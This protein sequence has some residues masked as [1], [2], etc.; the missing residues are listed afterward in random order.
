MKILIKTLRITAFKGIRDLTLDL[1]GANAELSG[2][3]GTGKT[4]VYDAYLWLLFGK[5]ST[6][7]S[8]F[9]VKPL[10]SNGDRLTGV[11]TSVECDILAGGKGVTLKRS[12]HEKWSKVPGNAQP[13]YTGDETLCWIDGVPV[14]LVNEYQPYINQLVGGEDS[15]KLLSSHGAFMRLPWD[16]QRKYL[17]EASGIDVDA[18]ILSRDEFIGVPDVL[19][20]KSPEDARKRIR[21]QRKRFNDTL[22]SIP[23]R[24][25]EL[26]LTLMPV[27]D[28][29]QENAEAA[30]AALN[31]DV[32][33]INNLISGGEE[34]F[35]QAR[36]LIDR[37][38][39]LSSKLALAKARLDA[40]AIQAKRAVEGAVKDAE[41]RR[42]MLRREIARLNEEVESIRA[43]T[44]RKQDVREAKLAEWHTVNGEAYREPSIETDCPYCKRPLPPDQIDAARERMRKT[45]EDTQTVRLDQITQTGKTIAE[46]IN[47]LNN[48]R[49][50]IQSSIDR[51]SAI[52]NEADEDV[53]RLTIQMQ[54]AD[55][56][57][58]VNYLDDPEYAGLTKQLSDL[59]E[60]IE[61]QQRMNRRDDLLEQRR[62]KQAEIDRFRAVVAQKEQTVRIEARIADLERQKKDVGTEIVRIDGQLDLLDRFTSAR[63]AAMEDGIN[64]MF[65]TIRWKLFDMQKNGEIVDCCRATVNGVPYDTGLNNAARINAGIEV[66]RVLSKSLGASVPCFVDNSEAVNHLEYTGGQMILLRVSDDNQLTLKKED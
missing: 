48:E 3:N 11:D 57:K 58:P 38:R 34:A 36:E 25:D 23:E 54:S 9:D 45:W 17:V 46:D 32:D 31:A 6:G 40:P 53:K 24:I 62:Q 30:I 4:S 59:H 16:Q 13:V 55:E 27:D 1:N 63:C 65:S 37:E 41:I 44:K 56:P 8:K 42:D 10:D 43:D 22:K 14:K 12:W 29:E 47:R 64:A 15:F 61:V 49:L 18:E 51:K 50:E 5:D 2:K 20:G 35:K 66:I 21:D 26:R 60:E 33:T 39:S 52:A 19:E 28:K 7:A